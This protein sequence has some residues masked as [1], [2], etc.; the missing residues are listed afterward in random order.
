MKTKVSS[1]G[2]RVVQPRAVTMEPR[3]VTIKGKHVV[4]DLPEKI[5]VSD[6]KRV[7]QVIR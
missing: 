3:A 7:I 2:K 6:G 5:V 4:I 1:G